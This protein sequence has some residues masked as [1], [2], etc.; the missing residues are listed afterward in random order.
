MFFCAE[1]REQIKE[2]IENEIKSMPN[3][4][5]DYETV[6]HFIS[7]EELKKNHSA[8][9]HGG[10]SHTYCWLQEKAISKL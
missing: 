3:Y 6:V 8:M 5:S 2:K 10:R 1:G 7:E 9:P 4:F